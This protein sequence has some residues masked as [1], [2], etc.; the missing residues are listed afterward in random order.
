MDDNDLFEDDFLDSKYTWANGQSGVHRILCKLD[1]ALTNEAWL[2]KFENW[3]CKSLPHEVSDQST[4]IGFPFANSRPKRAPFRVQ[5]IW[6]SHPD[7]MCMVIESWNAPVSGS[8]AFIFH[9]KLKRLKAAMKEW[10]LWVFGN[11]YANIKQAKLTMEVALRISDEDPE[12]ITKLN[13]A[14]KAS[15]TLQE[16]RS[17]HSIML[18]QKSRN[19]WLI[20]GASNTSFFQ[21]N[22]RTR[23]SSNM[24]SELV[25]D[26]G[27]VLTDCDQIRDYAVSFFESKFNGAELPIDEDL[28]HYDHSS[29]SSE[30]SQRMDEI[31][32]MEEIK[33]AIF[34]LGVDSAPG[35]DGFSGC[36]YRH[37]WNV[38]QQ[39][40]YNA[41]TYC[42]QEK[43]IP[44]G[45][46]SSLLIL[47]SKRNKLLLERRNI[48][49]NIS[50]ASE[51][52]ND[53]KTKRKDR[54]VGLKLDITQAFDTGNLRSL[55][56]LLAL[57]GKYQTASGQTV[58]H[59]K[60][61]VYYG[62]GS[63]S[64][65][66]TITNLLG[67]KVAT[68]PDKYLGV[69]IMPGAVKYSHIS[70]VIDKIKNQ[71]AICKGKLLSFQN[72]FV[73]INLVISSYAIHN[74]VVYKWP[75]KF[76]QQAERV[77]RNFLW[78]GDAEVARKFVVGFPKV[79]CPLKEGGLGTTSM[80]VTNEALLMKLWWSIRS[81]SK[82]WARFLWAK[83]TSRLGRIK[84]YGVNSSILSGI[85]LIYPTVD[86]NTK[87]L[88]GD[89]RNTSLYFDVWY[90]NECITDMLGDN[91]L[92]STVMV[93]V[94]IVNNA[95]QVQGDH[96]KN[97][98]RAG[99]D[100]NNLPVL[101]GGADIR[102][103]MPDLY[104]KFT[105]RSAK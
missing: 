78:S 43:I 44:Q 97:L 95:W 20:D 6:F 79:C 26:N 10:N 71:L 49:E 92:D 32:T 69:Q 75:K 98:A 47:L 4:L 62:G 76:I 70:N 57:L 23:R 101:Q 46:N 37:C 80:A 85:R 67:M 5:K 8:P 84:K 72:I 55:H 41:I 53:L 16:I 1:R 9:F 77:I 24:I 59:Q 39:D 89:G 82:K 50:V 68:F 103:W 52:I 104:G 2:N 19:K 64:R 45:T 15:V 31:P 74:M 87:V 40:L 61:K 88:L 35:P 17:Q 91:D 81:S 25:D 66:R 11:V 3:R 18:K 54:N 96:A 7:F 29:I 36:F 94:V 86:R 48:H 65:C 105:V 102:V 38:L 100:L 22:I 14:K 93:S 28:F 60:S 58:Y 83:Y 34:D 13:S 63:L 42:W 90:G 21:T 51:M 12:D 73:L 30:D 33:T 99:V 27:N 56:N